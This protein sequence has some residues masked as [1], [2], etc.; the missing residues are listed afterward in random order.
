MQE[1]CVVAWWRFYDDFALPSENRF[2][3][4]KRDR[5][6]CLSLEQNLSAE[7]LRVRWRG[8]GCCF[9]FLAA[10]ALNAGGFAPEVA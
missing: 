7:L 5:H 8:S 4:T 1:F 10:G 9:R 3:K 6:C 2:A